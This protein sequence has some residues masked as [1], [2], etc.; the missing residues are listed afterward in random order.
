[1]SLEDDSVPPCE[2]PESSVLDEDLPSGSGTLVPGS[3]GPGATLLTGPGFAEADSVGLSVP[4]PVIVGLLA[5]GVVLGLAGL[6]ST[7][8][9]LSLP[10]GLALVG[11]PDGNVGLADGGLVAKHLGL[12][13]GSL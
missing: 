11:L 4:G 7:G 10:V 12:F 13:A 1:M 3:L 8:A 2:E 9:V 6:D 5:P